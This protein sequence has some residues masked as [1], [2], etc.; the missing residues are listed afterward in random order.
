MRTTVA[1]IYIDNLYINFQ[2]IKSIV[3]N[4]KIIGV[5]K[6]NAYGH[7]LIEVSRYLQEFGIDYLAVA[8]ASEGIA[9]REAGI[10]IP[11]LVLVPENDT[12]IEASV[13]Y[14][15]EYAVERIEV[16]EA[17]SSYAKLKG[18]N[19]KVHIY[20]DTGM[21]RDGIAVENSIELVHNCFNLANINP[22]GIMSHFA[23]SEKDKDYTN[24]QLQRFLNLVDELKANGYEFE[25]HHIAN[26][27]ALISSPESYLDT[28]RPG[29]ALYGYIHNQISTSYEFK[30]VMEIYSKVISLRRL[31]S[32]E[33]TGYGRKFIAEKET[34][35]ATVPIG[36]G[37]GL[38][39][40]SEDALWCLIKGKRRKVV[41]GICMDEIM[42][43]VGD[44]D[45][46]L[47]DEVVILG[48]QGCEKITGNDLASYSKTIVYEVITSFSKRI[49]KIYIQN[50]TKTN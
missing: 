4:R 1:K 30:P 39:K 20:V 25:M 36:Y 2:N 28:V 5:V 31:K 32:G 3:G 13:D 44:D 6:A 11:I 33:S 40:T 47:G 29:L 15:L 34:T 35:I 17:I 14:D 27:G 16:V 42:V 48:S 9:L 43:D 22:I 24:K 8:F 12:T 26:T 7:G 50:G 10:K 45:V 23:S 21:G 49:P 41:G 37:D 46:K 38:L 18:K 19:A